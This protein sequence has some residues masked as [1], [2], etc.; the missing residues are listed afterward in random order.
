[1]F[2]HS[3]LFPL[4]H[5]LFSPSLF[6]PSLSCPFLS[7]PSQHIWT[8]VT[9]SSTQAFDGRWKKFGQPK[10][11]YTVDVQLTLDQCRAVRIKPAEGKVEALSDIASLTEHLDT[12]KGYSSIADG[13]YGTYV[14][15][16]NWYHNTTFYRF[17]CL[18]NFKMSYYWIA[19]YF[20]NATS[21]SILS[22]FLSSQLWHHDIMT[23]LRHSSASCRACSYTQSRNST[24]CGGSGVRSVRPVRCLD[25]SSSRAQA[26]HT[27]KRYVR[28]YVSDMM[29]HHS[30]AIFAALRSNLHFFSYDVISY[31]VMCCYVVIC[32]IKSCHDVCKQQWE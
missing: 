1:M 23:S 32:H 2:G 17:S 4:F 30:M 24:T 9:S 19:V 12:L 28:V 16:H 11:V 13:L 29:Q 8:L 26:Y 25:S 3:C 31:H 20:V 18:D 21:C 10:F 5:V 27:W 14:T 15:L 22:F 7:L 6:F